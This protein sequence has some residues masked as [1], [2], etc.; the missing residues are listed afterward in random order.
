VAIFTIVL[1]VSTA[2]LWW[3]TR[4]TLRH[5]QID[6][7]RQAG[8]MQRS[9]AVAEENAKAA[10]RAAEIAEK[11][12]IAIDRPWLQIKASLVGPLEFTEEEIAV[13]VEFTLL[14]TGRSPAMFV[15]LFTRLHSDV[16]EAASYAAE[17]MRNHMGGAFIG[18]GNI[19]FPNDPTEPERRILRMDRAAFIQRIKETDEMPGLHTPEE[20]ADQIRYTR[21]AP[22]VSALVF[23]GLPSVPHSIKPN[24]TSVIL[25]IRL[26]GDL[27]DFKETG[28]DGRVRSVDAYDLQLKQSFMSGR[29]S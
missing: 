7:E 25:D 27:A 29:A 24:Y 8:D 3:T 28:F 10:K 2:L 6:S 21:A 9:L 13:E 16:S 17:I 14:N 1:T 26:K 18:T 12:M 23:Y 4:E 11:S 5:A 20:G 15:I 22:G 19:L